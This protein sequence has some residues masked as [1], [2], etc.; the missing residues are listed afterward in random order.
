M[1]P[2]QN[3]E[4]AAAESVFGGNDLQAGGTQQ[5]TPSIVTDKTATASTTPTPPATTGLSK[6]DIAGIL[7]QANIGQPAPAAPAQKQW[8][9]TEFNQMFSVYDAP[10]ELLAKLAD[11]EHGPAAFRQ[12]RDGLLKQFNTMSSYQMRQMEERLMGHMKP[13]QTHA[14]Q[15]QEA[16]MKAEFFGKHA[17]LKAH[18]PLLIAIRD[19]L[20]MQVN[21]G[22]HPPF[23][24]KEEVFE[25]INSRAREVLKT[26]VPQNGA[27][28][29][30][31]TQAA[32]TTNR[33]STVSTG[34]QG[35]SG[36]GGTAAKGTAESLFG[37]R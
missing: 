6:D 2:Q 26:M 17:D 18:E 19:Q 11:P 4:P 10:T 3:N 31:R 16:E 20:Q 35:G 27:P 21:S 7:K 28:Q 14:Q 29:G 33:M 36:G 25:A 23:K 1:E 30:A 12:L 24:T 9:E 8:T 34:G 37:R 5:E 32:R 13:L 22:A 15:Q